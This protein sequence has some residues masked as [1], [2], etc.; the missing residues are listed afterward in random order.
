MISIRG[1]PLGLLFL[2]IYVGIVLAIGL[3][4]LR[5]REPGYRSGIIFAI[6]MLT[7]PA[8]VMALFWLYQW[9]SQK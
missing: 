3:S 6:L 5:H 1:Y 8:W 2:G 9:A 7:M 4:A